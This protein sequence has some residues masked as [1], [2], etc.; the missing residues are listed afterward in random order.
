[1]GKPEEAAGRPLSRAWLT[2][3][4]ANSP[5][6]LFY[7]WFL[8]AKH[9]RIGMVA[10]IVLWWSL[11]HLVCKTNRRLGLSLVAGG[12]L[13]ALSQCFPL[14]QIIAGMV[15]LN[16]Y[17]RLAQAVAG[18][19]VRGPQEQTEFGGFLVTMLTGGMLM[20]VALGFGSVIRAV[21]FSGPWRLHSKP[22]WDGEA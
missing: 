15:S 19:S 3:F 14:L 4:L 2:V 10:A 8:T 18:G 12:I 7:A 11:G 9:G 22:G 1:M 21:I 16:I 17:G 20:A 13:V 6:P 5:V